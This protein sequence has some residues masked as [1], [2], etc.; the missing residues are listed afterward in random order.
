PADEVLVRVFGDELPVG[1]GFK[2]KYTHREGQVAFT[3]VNNEVRLGRRVRQL[4]TMFQYDLN[5]RLFA[6]IS[7]RME[8]VTGKPLKQLAGLQ[9]T[10][11]YRQA[12]YENWDA[13]LKSVDSLGIKMHVGQP[14][15]EFLSLS[16]RDIVDITE[17]SFESSN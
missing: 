3:E 12:F 5:K 13:L 8:D 15:Q 14:G 1:E 7:K 16:Y 6:A 2:Q 11:V 9:R 17:K 4:N 10:Q